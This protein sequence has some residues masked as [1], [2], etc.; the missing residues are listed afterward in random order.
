[1]RD[2][3]Y[4]FILMI[5]LLSR[6]GHSLPE[7]RDDGSTTI[8]VDINGEGDHISIQEAIDSARDGDLIEVRPGSYNESLT[9][10]I[11][12]TL[13]GVD[14]NSTMILSN[15]TGLLIRSNN[16]TVA[17]FN[18][19]SGSLDGTG[20]EIDGRSGCTV[21]ECSI[22]GF[23]SGM[24][25]RGSENL[26]VNNKI[27][28]NRYGI[29]VGNPTYNSLL[30]GN[31]YTYG[32]DLDEI[33]E[34]LISEEVSSAFGKK[35]A[36]GG[37]T[38]EDHARFAGTPL[39]QWNITLNGGTSW[40]QVILQD[41]SQI[42][43]FPTTDSYWKKSLSGAK[44]LN[45]M[46]ER[47][48]G[49]TIFLMTWG[50][51]N[52]DPMNPGIY[53]NYTA[54]QERLEIGYNRYAENCSTPERPAYI[55]PVGLAWKYIHDSLVDK[56]VDPTESGNLFYDLF[57]NDGSHP[58]IFGSYL[59]G[60][61]IYSTI[62]GISPVGLPGYSGINSTYMSMLQRAAHETVFNETPGYLYPWENGDMIVHST[63]NLIRSNIL[64]NNS[65]IGIRILDKWDNRNSIVNNDFI[66]NAGGGIQAED[67]GILNRWDDGHKGNYWSDMVSRYPGSGNDG[68]VWDTTYFISDSTG[69][70]FPL[71][72]SVYGMDLQDPIA[73]AGGYDFSIYQFEI[74]RFNGSR[75]NDDTGI[76]NFT[77]IFTYNVQQ[78]I[79]HGIDPVFQFEIPG[80]YS[81]NLTVMDA[82]GNSDSI[83]FLIHVI[84]TIFPDTT[85]PIP[86]EGLDLNR[87]VFIGSV[88][89][90]ESGEWIDLESTIMSYSW[91]FDTNNDTIFLE[92]QIFEFQ[93]DDPGEFLI[94]LNVTNSE[95]LSTYFSIS[96]MV[97]PDDIPPEAHA[98][99]DIVIDQHE[100]VI[101][102]GTGSIDRESYILDHEWTIGN[103]SYNS[104]IVAIRFDK[105]GSFQAILNVTDA[106]GNWDLDVIN[107]TVKDITLPVIRSLENLSVRQHESV[108]FDATGSSDNVGI[109]EFKWRV[110]DEI[111]YETIDA[112]FNYSFHRMGIFKVS[113]SLSDEAE[114]R[115][116][117]SIWITVRDGEVPS[118]VF[119]YMGSNITEGGSLI[120]DGSNSSDNVGIVNWTW[121]VGDSIHYGEVVEI[122]FLEIGA[123]MVILTV[124]D[125]E[126]LMNSTSV[127]ITV[128]KEI[129]LPDENYQD[130][131]GSEKNDKFTGII[132]V[133]GI[134]LILM[135]VGVI[136]IIARLRYGDDQGE[137]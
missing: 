100:E 25:I 123:Y 130:E 127:K 84:Q 109:T 104:S 3:S 101:F 62:T 43:G 113:L 56:G 26:V 114:N 42:P 65:A 131:E 111:I 66:R 69:D 112:T 116:N 121:S 126:G 77:W 30:V 57:S 13:R 5:L 124:Y 137:E 96:M 2:H 88:I 103:E 72:K 20:I 38:L 15:G 9:I 21:R 34:K 107:I 17:G 55:A 132:I 73:D 78:I 11:K 16:V 134:I 122:S 98:G 75:S 22:S 4:I 32:N 10:D 94:I 90:L 28:K 118:A 92:G 23:T 61:V 93:F 58:S 70:D 6:S 52:G 44:A 106:Y 120:F 108:H 47:T 135:I 133:T 71:V 14:R 136:L 67:N 40:E 81:I 79:L 129:D 85:P 82:V 105:A 125:A 87:I 31:S 29:V 64:F 99:G 115:V 83:I 1:M 35:L 53:S 49:D 46:I 119:F 18:I 51:L 50:R 7:V 117:R 24:V 39:H 45:E 37:A 33:V 60:C 89:V 27:E 59:T 128:E 95:G 86:P 36:Q 102:N 19:I 74:F 41:Q 80:N 54:M 110:E 76:T 68:L 63:E 8:I 91:R 97:I 48:G 12:L